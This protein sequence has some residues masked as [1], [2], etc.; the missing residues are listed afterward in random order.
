VV[1]VAVEKLGLGEAIAY[2]VMIYRRV[3]LVRNLVLR[4]MVLLHVL[5]VIVHGCDD[6]MPVGGQQAGGE[7]DK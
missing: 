2:K 5:F 3:A 1:L 7:E 4:L 6:W